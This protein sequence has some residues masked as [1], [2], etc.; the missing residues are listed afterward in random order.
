MNSKKHNS[1]QMILYLKVD[2]DMTKSHFTPHNSL[3]ESQSF[4]F[5][6]NVKKFDFLK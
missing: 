3:V 4:A 5:W 6:R 1:W 2:V